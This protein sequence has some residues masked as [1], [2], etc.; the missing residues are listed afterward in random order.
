[1]PGPACWQM[2]LAG[3]IEVTR[4]YFLKKGY[5]KIWEFWVLACTPLLVHPDLGEYRSSAPQNTSGVG[6]SDRGVV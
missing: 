1:M 3:L 6:K 2:T 4:K 5:H